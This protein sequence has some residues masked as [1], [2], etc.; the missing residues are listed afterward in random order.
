MLVLRVYSLG[1]NVYIEKE[2]DADTYQVIS[3]DNEGH[4]GRLAEGITTIKE[5]YEVL[6]QHFEQV[7]QEH[8]L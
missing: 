7:E 6:E 4:E 2:P 3:G 1:V 5:L 8:L